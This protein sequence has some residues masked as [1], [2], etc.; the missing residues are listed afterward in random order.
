MAKRCTQPLGEAFPHA[1]DQP[2][3]PKRMTI[4]TVE[5]LDALPH[6]AVIVDNHK[7]PWQKIVPNHDELPGVQSLWLRFGSETAYTSNRI[8]DWEPFDVLA[9]DLTT[10]RRYG[11]LNVHG[12][13]A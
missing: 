9:T 2:G 1:P 4:S 11:A 8:T 3:H 10:A 6:G 7:C 12:A 13:G 5:E